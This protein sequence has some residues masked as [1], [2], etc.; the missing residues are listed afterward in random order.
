MVA[1]ATLGNVN[2]TKD[3]KSEGDEGY[4]ENVNRGVYLL[5]LLRDRRKARA[6]DA[7]KMQN[8]APEGVAREAGVLTE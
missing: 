1:A 3:R 6:A 2:I 8:G 5:Y 7:E 4:G